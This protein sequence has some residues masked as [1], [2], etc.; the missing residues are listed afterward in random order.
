VFED[1]GRDLAET[2]GVLRHHRVFQLEHVDPMQIDLPWISHSSSWLR[3]SRTA[4]GSMDPNDF[5]RPSMR[6]MYSA[7][8]HISVTCWCGAKSAWIIEQRDQMQFGVARQFTYRLVHED[9]AAVNGRVNGIRR[10]EQNARLS[11]GRF[12]LVEAVAEVTA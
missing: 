1:D 2:P 5:S 9:P 6:T 4:C 11:L 8:A 10:N 7:L 12:E 3:N